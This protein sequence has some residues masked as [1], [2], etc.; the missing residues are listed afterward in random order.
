[1]RSR[2]LHTRGRPFSLLSGRNRDDCRQQAFALK[3]RVLSTSFDSLRRGPL[4]V[5]CRPFRLVRAEIHISMAIDICLSPW[6]TCWRRGRD[7]N[8]RYRC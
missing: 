4:A 5:H 1:M 7:S 8:P 6:E 2:P 3:L